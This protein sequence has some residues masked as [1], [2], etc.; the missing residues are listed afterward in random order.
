MLTQSRSPVKKW[1]GKERSRSFFSL[2]LCVSIFSIRFAS[3][4]K[5]ALIKLPVNS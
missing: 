4:P 1:T 2:G 3:E 5:L